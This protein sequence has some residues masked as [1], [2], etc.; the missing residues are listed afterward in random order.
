MHADGEGAAA[1]DVANCE[2]SGHAELRTC[3]SFCDH[4][5]VS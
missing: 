1:G 3:L 4:A 5:D 2:G